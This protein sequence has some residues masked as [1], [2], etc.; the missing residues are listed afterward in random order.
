MKSEDIKSAISFMRS[1]EQVDKDKI[2]ATGIC[3]GG[4]YILQT[5]VGE[6]RIKAVATVSGTLMYI[7]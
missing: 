4:G 3:A 5:A 6:R 2:G 7:G 1:L